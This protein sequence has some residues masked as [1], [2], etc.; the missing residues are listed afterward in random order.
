MFFIIIQT[1][2]WIWG[3]T[4]PP[5]QLLWHTVIR[6]M[7]SLQ[8]FVLKQGFR[9]IWI[10]LF[11]FLWKWNQIIDNILW[12]S[13]LFSSYAL[14]IILSW[15]TWIY[16]ICFNSYVNED[17]AIR[18]VMM[19]LDSCYK[20]ITKLFIYHLSISITIGYCFHFW[21]LSCIFFVTIFWKKSFKRLHFLWL[22]QPLM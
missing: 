10:C 7:I 4:H 2:R 1:L 14:K 19:F 20:N 22:H 18:F 16:L 12:Y 15:H 3:K 6:N 5:V 21:E 11:C 9:A 13:F 17:D 8:L